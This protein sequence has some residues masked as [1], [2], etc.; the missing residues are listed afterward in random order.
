MTREITMSAVSLESG[1]TVIRIALIDDS[2]TIRAMLGALFNE[3][4]EIDVCAL[5]ENGEEGVA[6]VLAE[7]PDVVVM[8]MQMPLLNGLDAAKEILRQWP[9]ARIIMNTAYGDEALKA[10]ADAL[11]VAGYITK[12]ER[13]SKL[14]RAVISVARDQ[15]RVVS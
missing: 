10:E 13:P 8:D 15:G 5:G 2:A 3:I 7:R 14:V 1:R 12:D 11:G 4:P 9:E 6:V